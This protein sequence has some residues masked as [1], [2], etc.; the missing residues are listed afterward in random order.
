MIKKKKEKRKESNGVSAIA[1]NGKVEALENSIVLPREIC[2]IR[3]MSCAT[4][5]CVS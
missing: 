3:F 4:T 5:S 1:R 2:I